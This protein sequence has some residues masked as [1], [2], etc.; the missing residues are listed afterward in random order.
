MSPDMRGPSFA[1]LPDRRA[2]WREFGLSL[3]TQGLAILALVWV[4][5]LHPE[6]LAPPYHDYHFIQLVSTPA[7]V[8]HE[9]APVRIIEPPVVAKLDSSKLKLP[10]R[11]APRETPVATSAPPKIQAANQ[12][13]PVPAA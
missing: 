3:S 10:A 2:P 4:G 1:V 11:I 12:P 6:V 13:I 5:V 9:P 7:P 8:P